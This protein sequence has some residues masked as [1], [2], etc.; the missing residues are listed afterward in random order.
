MLLDKIV[1]LEKDAEAFGFKW[2]TTEQILAQIQSEYHEVAEQLQQV[3]ANPA[4]LEEELG[5]LLHAVFSLCVFCK[6][7]PQATLDKAL[8]KFERRLGAVKQLA[9]AEGL[10]TLESHSFEEL[11]AYWNKAKMMVD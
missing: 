6:L 5:D 4:K 8:I 2:E 7:S 10:M 3:D 1:K 11:M 9:K